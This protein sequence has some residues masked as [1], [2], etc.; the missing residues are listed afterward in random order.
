MGPNVST[1]FADPLALALTAV[2]SVVAT[3]LV[4]LAA[5]YLC[6]R[7]SHLIDKI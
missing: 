2:G 6:R 7:Y 3:V 4:T 5:V 1:F